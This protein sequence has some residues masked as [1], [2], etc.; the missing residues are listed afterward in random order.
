[1]NKQL[2]SLIFASMLSL[3]A[4]AV[5]DKNFDYHVDNFADIEVLR[6]E[7]P[8]FDRLSLNQK[9]WYTIC[10]RQLNMAATSSGTRTGA[11]TSRFGNSLKTSTL[12]IKG[13]KNSAEFKA[14][15]KYLKTSVVWKRIH[16]HYSTNKFRLNSQKLSS[17]SK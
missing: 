15:E 16:H 9:K 14:F 13:D 10:R 11:T 1:M 6:Y 3:Q 2:T 17:K 4:G 5:V 7:V 8:E 12:I